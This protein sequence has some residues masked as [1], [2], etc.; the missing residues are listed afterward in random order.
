MSWTLTMSEPE[1]HN[2][3]LVMPFVVTTDN[4]GPLDSHAFVAGVRYGQD[5]EAVAK[6]LPTWSNYI[7]PDMVAQYDLLAMHYGYKMEAEPWDEHPDEWVFVTFTRD[8]LHFGQGGE[9][10]H[11]E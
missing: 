7:Y 4:G 3:G 6:L 9:V 10:G 11:A 1:H 5:S 2:F 8:G